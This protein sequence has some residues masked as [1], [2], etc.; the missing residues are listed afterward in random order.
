MADEVPE[1]EV[2]VHLQPPP[3]PI[4]SHGRCEKKALEAY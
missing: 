1:A 3:F 4:V 2:P